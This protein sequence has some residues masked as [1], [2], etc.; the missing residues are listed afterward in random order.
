MPGGHLPTEGERRPV[1]PDQPVTRFAGKL[2]RPTAESAAFWV[3]GKNSEL[4]IQRCAACLRYHHPPGPVCPFCLDVRVAP[5]AV[6]GLGRVHSFTI[7]WQSWIAGM[8]VPFVIAYVAL[9]EQADVWLMTNIVGCEPGEV[10]IDQ[11]VRV[12]FEQQG[13]VWL[14]LFRPRDGPGEA[15]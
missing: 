3:G 12:V 13:D 4:L 15:P 10:A 6:S 8:A 14:P 5:H 1:R 9:E 7:N 11:P 2:P